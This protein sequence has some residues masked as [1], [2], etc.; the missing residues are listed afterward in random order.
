MSIGEWKI[1]L[2]ELSDLR[3]IGVPWFDGSRRNWPGVAAVLRDGS[4]RYRHNDTGSPAPPPRCREALNRPALS[5]PG[6][7]ESG[8]D[9][10]Q[11]RRL[12]EQAGADRADFKVPA[13]ENYRST[14]N[15]KAG[16]LRQLSQDPSSGIPR[17]AATD[18]SG[19]PQVP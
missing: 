10:N 6:P 13:K 17:R 3:D 14:S 4:C 2:D 11:F 7:S 8:A 18:R 19:A 1:G 9:A 12:G 5:H 15:A 16:S